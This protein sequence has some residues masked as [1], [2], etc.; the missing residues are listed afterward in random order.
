LL[1]SILKLTTN[2][3]ATNKEICLKT[4]KIYKSKMYF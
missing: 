4:K 2:L 1:F 3:L